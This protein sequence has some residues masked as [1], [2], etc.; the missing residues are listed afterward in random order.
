MKHSVNI[1]SYNFLKEG[2]WVLKVFYDSQTQIKILKDM[3]DK[4]A[5]I[6]TPSTLYTEYCTVLLLPFSF[7]QYNETEYW[8]VMLFEFLNMEF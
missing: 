4:Y 2:S 5:A 3:T 6:L 1:L 8:L 7:L